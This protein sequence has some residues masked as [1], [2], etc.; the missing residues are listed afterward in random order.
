MYLLISF[1]N[2][3]G[4][5]PNRRDLGEEI[6]RETTVRPA[7]TFRDFGKVAMGD[8]QSPCDNASCD[9]PKEKHLDFN[10]LLSRGRWPRRE[11]QPVFICVQGSMTAPFALGQQVDGATKV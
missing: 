1:T 2:G 11:T 6:W 5:V 9:D 3:L 4:A 7:N 8:V 10:L